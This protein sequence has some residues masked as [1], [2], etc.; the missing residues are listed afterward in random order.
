MIIFIDESGIHKQKEHSTIVL[1]YIEIV[2]LPELE[3]EILKIEKKLKIPSF[4]WAE[5]G[6]KVR[7]KFIKAIASLKFTYKVAILQNPIYLP[8]EL[9]KVLLHLVV[10]KNIR[11]IIIDGKKPRWYERRLKKILRDKGISVRK[12]KTARADSSPGLHLADALAGLIRYHHDKP[13]S[14]AKNLYN[15]IKK[16][17]TVQLVDGQ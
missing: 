11:K 8:K 7:E 15:L 14:K 12:L 1:V 2:V 5:H 10:E 13:K 6:W 16:K 9:E 17:Q 3:Q 4:H